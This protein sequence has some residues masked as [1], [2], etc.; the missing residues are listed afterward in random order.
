MTDLAEIIENV[1]SLDKVANPLAD[2]VGKVLPAGAVKDAL[3]GTRLGHPIHP[4]LT[5]VVIGAWTSALVLDLV[6]GEASEKAADALIGV[7][8]MAVAPTALA[9]LSDWADSWGK[10]RRLGIAHAAANVTA[11][12]CYAGSLIARKRGNRGAGKA[13]SLAGAG[14]LTLGGYLGG[15]LSFRLGVGVDQTTFDEGPAEWQPLIDLAA[16]PEATPT[17]ATIDGIKLLLYRRGDDVRAIADRCTHRGGPLHEGECD[18]VTV[19]CPWHGSRFRLAD[20]EI[21]RG[22]AIAPQPRFECRIT[23]GMVEV[24]RDPAQLHA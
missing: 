13:L 5:D 24:R 7:G 19:T 8:L 10:A 14:V 15:H 4:P 22:P 16:V 2:Q 6:G 3:S 17:T 1:E 11:S 18:G 21:I 9:G 23:G 12:V 20:G